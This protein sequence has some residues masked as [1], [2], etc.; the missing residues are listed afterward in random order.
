MPA[1]TGDEL[2]QLP[3][4]LFFCQAHCGLL[5]PGDH[6]HLQPC[7]NHSG[8][9]TFWSYSGH[10]GPLHYLRH[11]P[12]PAWLPRVSLKRK[13]RGGE[14]GP[15]TKSL[16][17]CVRTPKVRLETPLRVPSRTGLVTAQPA[18]PP[19]G[20]YGDPVGREGLSSLTT[21]RS[22]QVPLMRLCTRAAPVLAQTAW[23]GSRQV[24]S[25]DSSNSFS[26]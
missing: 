17:F 21:S 4:P 13:I 3:A 8:K 7:L 19:M 1:R 9:D 22:F 26:V 20:G 23:N 5:G 6:P 25:T 16:P 24:Q 18:R 15:L 10:L 11:H 12:T 2:Q 14:T